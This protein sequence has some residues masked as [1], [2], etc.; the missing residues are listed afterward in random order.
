MIERADVILSRILVKTERAKKH[1]TDV[2]SLARDARKG[3]TAFPDPQK[4]RRG[5]SEQI[6]VVD[7]GVVSGAGDTVHNLRSALDHLAWELAKWK[8][9]LPKHP[10]YCSFPIGRSLDDYKAIKGRAVAGMSPE[11]KKAIDDLSPY[12][13]ST[14]DTGNEPLWRIHHLDIVDKHRHML[15]AGYKI[16]FSG[17]KLPGTLSL[18][19]EEPAHFLGLFDDDFQGEE[20]RSSQPT[21]AELEV[22]HMKPLVPTLHEL[23]VFTESVIK[24]FKPHL[25]LRK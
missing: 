24:S 5:G 7:I 12:K 21:A 19:K 15:V 23:L 22:A 2:E 14:A 10:R 9:G 16:V 1:L 13:P 6:L 20:E 3:V 17:T 11:A 25:G 18:V 4:K 8:T